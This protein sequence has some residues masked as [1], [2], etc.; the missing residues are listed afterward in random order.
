[1]K[2]LLT[3]FV[4]FGILLIAGSAF[5]DGRI[6][7]G[8]QVALEMN[9]A[10]V[11]YTADINADGI[12]DIVGCDE[13]S[14]SLFVIVVYPNGTLRIPDRYD[15]GGEGEAVA[16]GDL[17]NDTYA[18]IIIGR[19]VDYDDMLGVMFGNGDGT[20]AD[21]VDYDLY[22]NID[23]I[24]VVDI[25]GDTD[26][27]LVATT[28]G[29]ISVFKNNG[30]GTLAARV[31]YASG[32]S[33]C[34]G[35]RAAD[36]D[37]DTDMDMVLANYNGET[38]VTMFNDG[39]GEYDSLITY[40]IGGYTTQVAVG[41]FD[42]NDS[43]DI[44]TVSRTGN[45]FTVQFNNGD[46]TYS[47]TSL[48]PT[49]SGPWAIEAADLNGDTFD[50]LI[51]TA[52][53]IEVVYVYM[54]NGDGTFTLDQ[55][56]ESR[57]SYEMT[58]GDYDQDG[59]IDIV[60]PD[61]ESRTLRVMYNDG[62]GQFLTPAGI[63][64]G[65]KAT[66]VR[67]GDFNDDTWI[68]FAVAN[69]D[70]DNVLLM[71]NNGDSTFSS[72]G[73]WTVGDGPIS[74]A[75]A[76]VTGDDVPDVITADLNANT[77]TVRLNDGA[78]AL[79]GGVNTYAE[80]N[81][82]HVIAARID[83]D[84]YNDLVI[85]CEGTDNVAVRINNGD[86]SFAAST[87]YAVSDGPKYVAAA[88]IDGDTDLDL[89]VARDGYYED[90]TNA[91]LINDGSGAFTDGTPITSLYNCR[92]VGAAE[93]DGQPGIDVVFTGD[94]GGVYVHRNNGD[95]TF[96]DP[97]W[98]DY[99]NSGSD[100]YIADLDQI[101]LPDVVFTYDYGGYFSVLKNYGAALL[102]EPTSYHIGA[103][104]WSIWGGDFD[105]DGDIDLVAAT[106]TTTGSVDT[107]YIYWNRVDLIPTDVDENTPGDDGVLPDAFTLGQNYPNPFNPSTTIEYS[108]PEGAHVTV[109]VYNILGQQV[110]R[111]VDAYRPAGTYTVTWDGRG[112]SGRTVSSGVYFYRIIA[113]DNVVAKK[114]VMVK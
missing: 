25:D 42:D 82:V 37:A 88:D 96:S 92:A 29:Y 74:L 8:S 40:S 97:V 43:P 86:G 22:N 85:V 94:D 90:R 48:Y 12:P 56:I 104:A 34:Y 55:E 46:G 2:H 7:E 83:G 59:D 18:D 61:E 23:E 4:L 101:A 111:L 87:Y 84:A 31:E 21:A 60:L 95:G 33:W 108:L 44:A 105:K 39:T 9:S 76:D 102:T 50:D 64:L 78:G 70:D 71:L 24:A 32:T 100:I 91:V 63:P 107:A 57:Y 103:Y 79:S 36:I 17:N 69:F 58:I 27:D 113:G 106:T 77:V 80:N 52:P 28:S 19:E 45:K 75:V 41:R 98:Y 81:P 30:D 114:M 10:R 89:V 35:I 53:Q 110:T 49:G 68:D 26:L 13:S 109:T 72:G 3:L 15:I 11:L 62:D 65:H 47:D 73:T 99:G 38:M 20:F 54:N 16:V 5:G 66:S 14:N 93:M 1:M 51:V 67:T 112:E 6:F